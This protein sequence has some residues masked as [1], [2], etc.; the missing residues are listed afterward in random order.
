MVESNPLQ[1]KND[2]FWAHV[3]PFGL[4]MACIMFLGEPAGWKYALRTALG[5]GA[6]VYFRPW[7]WYGRF[8]FKGLGWAL[9][10]GV[11]VFVLWVAPETRWAEQWPRFQHFYQV[12]CIIPPWALPDPVTETPYAPE[13]CGWTLTA[14]RL[15]GSAVVIAVIEEFF[16]R[17]FLYRWLVNEEFLSV[18]MKCLKWGLLLLTALFFASVHNRWLAGLITG[19]IYGLLI[20]RTGNIWAGVIAH[21]LTNLLLGIYVLQQEAYQFW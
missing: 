12:V 14:M 9:L 18:S 7:R 3:F 21:G 4:W 10:A 15:F 16:W 2:A 5:L 13:V 11:G 8:S 20:I 19:I 1:Q 6:L 17:G